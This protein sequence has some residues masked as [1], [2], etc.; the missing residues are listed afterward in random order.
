[1]HSSD[2]N[3]QC[4]KQE[5][6]GNVEF[7]PSNPC[8]PQRCQNRQSLT[9]FRSSFRISPTPVP[10]DHQNHFANALRTSGSVW[11]RQSPAMPALVSRLQPWRPGATV[12][13]PLTPSTPSKEIRVVTP[14]EESLKQLR[15]LKTEIG[16]QLKEERK[17]VEEFAT[18]LKD[19][20]EPAQLYVPMS[21]S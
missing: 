7:N 19:T 3:Q 14:L 9:Q 8:R 12:K 11:E 5:E 13:K 10:S 18:Q 20:N 2:K 17:I 4:L 16:E 1:M 21:T 15:K 6:T